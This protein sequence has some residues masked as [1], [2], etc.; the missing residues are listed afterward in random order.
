M[1]IVCLGLNHT[2]APLAM[3]ERVAFSENVLTESI[4]TLLARLNTKEAGELK[5]ALI[6]STCNRMEIYSVAEDGE[7]LLR[8]LIAFL[9]ETK[10]VSVQE[11]E[12]YTYSFLDDAAVRHACCVVAGIDSMVLGETQIAGQVKR[13]LAKSRAAH[14]MGLYLNRLFQCAFSAAKLVRSH[15]A[16]GKNTVSL[17]AAAVRL[18]E[19]IFGDLSSRR[20]LYIG[21]GEMIELCA[22]HFGARN[23]KEITVANRSIERGQA[24]AARHGGKA[25]RLQELPKVIA[26]FDVIVSCTA[27]ALPI[28][29]LG[30]VARAVKERNHEPICIID[31]AVPRDVEKEVAEL[32]DV[33]VYTI[34]D[35]GGVVTAGKESRAA[36]IEKAEE[37]V[38]KRVEEFK[39]WKAVREAVPAIRTLRERAKILGDTELIRAKKALAAG[40]DP[41]KVLERLTHNLTQ[42]F[43]HDPTVYLKE[44]AEE[45]GEKKEA[46]VANF[47]RPRHT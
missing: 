17:S 35:L 36:S 40:A 34:D 2:T 29:G 42:K 30:M 27:S 4:E 9:A 31:L 46:T 41:E 38:G 24:L 10:G 37:L 16:I 26:H 6:V 11:L 45:G 33:F 44:V 22:A 20:V 13:A 32:P 14:G 43:S 1:Q 15:T 5:E 7:K 23:P 18:S 21:A 12:T 47:F 19:R 8:S 25:I 39:R 3:R 28:L